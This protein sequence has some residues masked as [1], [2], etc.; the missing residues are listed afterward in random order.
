M[1]KLGIL[2]I[3]VV[4]LGIA[5]EFHA[6]TDEPPK[7]AQT[8][9]PP[10]PATATQAK[11]GAIA[12]GTL[13]GAHLSPSPAPT[14]HPKNTPGSSRGLPQRLRPGAPA[15]P[16][17]AVATATAP[18]A[19]ATTTAAPSAAPPPPAATDTPAAPVIHGQNALG[20]DQNTPGSW[21]GVVYFIPQDTQ[22]LPDFST[23]KPTASFYTQQINVAPRSFTDGFP[24][25]DNRF[26][27]FG[28]EYYNSLTVATEAD[29]WF[30]IVSDD[31]SKFY[32]DDTLIIDD[33]GIHPP[34]E[35]K[36]AAHLIAG[37]HTMRLDYFQGP[38]DQ[39][40]VQLFVT[41]PNAAEK[42][43]QATLP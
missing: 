32:I 13:G 23:I 41:P 27:W 22:K 35:K 6:G 21:H 15:A 11:P 25:V 36:G 29:Y 30:R 1:K 9:P 39:I 18:T 38:R 4:S 26:E 37:A 42:P 43:L 40:A 20:S 33:D 2:A 10:P 17:T 7:T 14:P 5:C 12:H 8:P 31:G 24:G 28:V 3:G 19:T 16:A 34:T